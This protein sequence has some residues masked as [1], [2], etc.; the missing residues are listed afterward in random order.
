MGDGCFQI[1]IEASRDW[2]AQKRAVET[3]WQQLGA[4]L[5]TIESRDC[6]NYVRRPA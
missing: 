6:Q 3:A 4:L 2:A 5:A 1:I